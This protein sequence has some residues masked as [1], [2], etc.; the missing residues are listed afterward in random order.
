MRTQSQMEVDGEADSR[1]KLA[2]RMESSRKSCANIES[3]RIWMRTPGQI[4]HKSGSKKCCK[5]QR[6]VV[7]ARTRASRQ[8]VAVFG[9]TSKYAR[10]NQ[11]ARI[12]IE[13]PQA[14]M[15]DKG[16]KIGSERLNEEELDFEIRALPAYEGRRGW[17]R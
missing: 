2:F 7:V 12:E 1:K 6:D 5:L 4:R 16:Q 15:E 9:H 10:R 11:Q 3:S 14:K 8:D 17:Y 13:R